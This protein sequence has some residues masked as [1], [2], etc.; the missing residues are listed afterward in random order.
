VLEREERSMA[1]IVARGLL[2]RGT[3]AVGFA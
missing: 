2:S 3:A 1:G